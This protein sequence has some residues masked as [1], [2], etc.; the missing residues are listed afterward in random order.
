MAAT[1]GERELTE[2][3]FK[4]AAPTLGGIYFIYGLPGTGKTTIGATGPAPVILDLEGGTDSLMDRD[5]VRILPVPDLA[6]LTQAYKFLAKGAH[7]YR[8]IVVDSL[9]E[10]HRQALK[11]ASGGALVPEQQHYN[12]ALNKLTQLVTAFRTLAHQMGYY[13]I[14]TA[15][16]QVKTFGAGRNGEAVRVERLPDLPPA[17]LKVLEQMADGIMRL[18]ITGGQRVLTLTAPNSLIRAKL[19][20][21]VAYKVPAEIPDP[22]LPKLFTLLRKDHTP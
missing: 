8:T 13:V 7:P 9:T 14:M 10:V 15:P 20:V 5:D 19:R 22:T 3:D 21:P 17:T 4:A 18:H 2:A 11:T 1:T 6:T 16:E 12:A